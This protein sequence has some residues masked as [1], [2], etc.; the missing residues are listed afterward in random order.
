[1]EMGLDLVGP[2]WPLK[3]LGFTVTGIDIGVLQFKENHTGC[4]SES[5]GTER[6]KPASRGCDSIPGERCAGS[7]A[8]VCSQ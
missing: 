3:C 6:G 7:H 5:K 2:C 1:M 8:R 4:C